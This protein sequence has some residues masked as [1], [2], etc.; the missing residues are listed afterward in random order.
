[1][2][3]YT[4]PRG[5]IWLATAFTYYLDKLGAALDF[6]ARQGGSLTDVSTPQDVVNYA[7][8]IRH[9][10]PAFADDLIAAANRHNDG[11]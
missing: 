3:D 7:N 1:V 11:L 10:Q 4:P 2:E 6:F 9:T 8:S 5:A